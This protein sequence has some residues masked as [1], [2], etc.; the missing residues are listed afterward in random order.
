MPADPAT[1]SLEPSSAAKSESDGGARRLRVTEIFHSIQGESTHAGR[2]SYF[3]R[4]TGCNLR[5]RWCD[6]EY[7]FS[8]GEWMTFDAIFERMASFPR[9]DLVEVTGG[10]PLLQPA[11][12]AFMA[13]CLERG[14]EVMLETGGSLDLSPVPKDVR[15][16]VDLKPPG[17]GEVD[18][19]RWENLPLLQ[20]WDE[21]KAVLADRRDYEWA[22][23]ACQREGLF[24]RVAVS[25][26]PVFG[27]LHPRQLA[28]W[29]LADALPARVQLQLHK[30]I[31]EPDARGV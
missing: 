23:D 1:P 15:K 29:V 7:T 20:P 11:V 28:E 9:C 16:I 27:E 18:R 25:F 22:R 26:S 21:I 31:W 6:S 5:C 3:V 19:N 14:F 30:F 13:E 4:L 24:G 17:S 8:G 10:E 2:P 12:N